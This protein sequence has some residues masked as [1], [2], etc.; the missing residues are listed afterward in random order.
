M[1]PSEPSANTP[2]GAPPTPAKGLGSTASVHLCRGRFRPRTADGRLRRCVM[3]TV[4]PGG[5]LFRRWG[6]A[7]WLS[8]SRCIKK[9]REKRKEI[10]AQINRLLPTS[11]DPH[12]TLVSC[13]CHFVNRPLGRDV[14][15]F[16]NR[17]TLGFRPCLL[18]KN[19]VLPRSSPTGSP[20]PGSSVTREVR[21]VR[22]RREAVCGAQEAWTPAL[23]C[24]RARPG[25]QSCAP[26][27]NTHTW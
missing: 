26:C 9:K 4:R 2:R 24:S 25:D 22:A 8:F 21:R 3:R 17:E 19:R 15:R 10:S 23:G 18:F 11:S 27:H 20:T 12:G 16:P 14:P 6:P 7:G 1:C 13:L 5:G